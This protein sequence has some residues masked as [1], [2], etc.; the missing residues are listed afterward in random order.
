MKAVFRSSGFGPA[1]LL[2]LL[3]LLVYSQAGS[4]GFVNFD[5]PLYVTKCDPVRGGLS[6][7]GFR[8]AF[9][10]G[11][12]GNWH[13][14]TWLSLM[15]DVSLFGVRA[16]AM[17][18]VN[19]G[20]HALNTLLLHR[21]LVAM[22][23]ERGLALWVAA[24]FAVHPAHVESVAWIS[25]RKDV[26]STF[27][28]LLAL[29]AYHRY[30]RRPTPGKMAQVGLWLGLG[31]MAKP[32]LVTWP[33][34]MLGL[35]L[36][37]YRRDTG[38]WRDRV[39]LLREKGPL[40]ILVGG[41]AALALLT[42]TRIGAVS[43]TMPWLERVA[44]ACL[45]CLRYVGITLWPV[46]LAAFYPMPTRSVLLAGG[47]VGGMLVLAAT[48]GLWRLRLRHPA[49]LA[50]WVWFLVS[51]LP[52][53]GLVKIG[54]QSIADRYTYVPMIGLLVLGAWGARP[55]LMRLL[56]GDRLRGLAAALSVLCLVPLARAQVTTWT[57]SQT[58]FR[59]AL[60]CTQGNFLAMANLGHA[61]AA[62]GRHQEALVWF[63]QSER[64][65]PREP[66]VTINLGNAL[67]KLGQP[68]EAVPYLRRAQVAS[69]RDLRPPQLLA[70][71]CLRLGQMDQA[72]S[73]AAEYLNL[74]ASIHPRGI[75]EGERASVQRARMVLGFHF[76]AAG[77]HRQASLVF[78]DAMHSN[79]ADLTARFNL[80]LSLMDLRR[81]N[82]AAEVLQEGL[83]MVPAHPQLLE[84]LARV[85]LDAGDHVS[86]GSVIGRM[87]ASHPGHAALPEL[88]RR[89]RVFGPRS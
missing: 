73:H 19:V 57:D 83:R 46:D 28:G 21:W 58:L 31:L 81:P 18:W 55:L 54:A 44:N 84:A 7:E 30:V 13:P 5:D 72:A 59:H 25:E 40:L 78:R 63:R 50:G 17:H 3:V 9:T 69:P 85:Y 34:L 48:W 12:S 49:L 6:W 68:A 2:V 53:I 76:R 75:P 60:D 36:W 71:A 79:P 4:L 64:I 65:A 33:L 32:M 56:P 27:L 42:Q 45:G 16:G 86:A 70:E 1:L 8:W 23:G 80:A 89:L 61:L 43:A 39:A 87:Q 24:V 52:V 67:L 37:P 26:L 15:L 47:A 88:E 77:D 11:T 66:V 29:L 10:E 20:F 35:D 82:E 62:E 41:A 51:L 22:T 38:R 74:L 14:L